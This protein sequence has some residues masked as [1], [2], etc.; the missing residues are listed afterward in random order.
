MVTYVSVSVISYAKKKSFK[1]G[2]PDN[3]EA[4]F[5]WAKLLQPIVG[6]N[7]FHQLA[8]RMCL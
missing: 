4:K 2:S 5:G 8:W 1:D 6:Q 7:S 3:G